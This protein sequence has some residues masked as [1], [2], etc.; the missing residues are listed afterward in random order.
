MNARSAMPA[1]GFYPASEIPMADYL[2]DPCPVPSL[3]SGAAHRLL[4]C[5]PLHC[6][7]QHPRLGGRG[8]SDNNASDMGSVTHDL[9]LGGEGKICVLNPEDYRS[10]PTKADPEGAIPV[11]FTNNA[12]RAARDEARANGLTPILAGA[13]AGARAMVEAARAFVAESEIAGVFDDGESEVTMLWQEDETW[14]R[15]RPDWLNHVGRVVLHYKTTKASANPEP[16]SRGVM[17]SMGYDVSL[18]F[19]RRGFER[20]TQQQR[21]DW[22]HVILCQEQTAPYACSLISLDR[23]AWAIADGKVERAIDIWRRCMKSGKWPGYSRNIHYATP[24]PW[25]LAEAEQ[26]LQEQ[27]A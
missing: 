9:L 1:P 14:F 8:S 27:Y 21:D 3:S 4:A 23:A 16:F 18:G 7:T 22:H 19:Y 13:I 24:T 20:L 25:Q 11:G 15:A 2:A 5:S 6:W 26:R 17:D 10:K 12:I